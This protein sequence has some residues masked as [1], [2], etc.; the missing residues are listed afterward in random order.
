MFNIYLFNNGSDIQNI[1]LHPRK[2][3]VR[4]KKSPSAERNAREA[5]LVLKFYLKVKQLS[6]KM[7]TFAKIKGKSLAYCQKKPVHYSMASPSE[8][9]SR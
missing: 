5:H 6:N 9:N 3:C 7:S 8:S 4:K 2:R 1:N